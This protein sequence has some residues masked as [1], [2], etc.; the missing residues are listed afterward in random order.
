MPEGV[1]YPLQQYVQEYTSSST[2]P[3]VFPNPTAG[4]TPQHKPQWIQVIGAGTVV[5]VWEDGSTGTL[6]CLGGE[7][8]QATMNQITSM[9]ATRVRVG[10][11]AP[12]PAIA[13]GTA[14]GITL[15]TAVT[16]FTS[17][18]TVDAALAEIYQDLETAQGVVAFDLCNGFLVAGTP[19]AAFADNAASA[20]GV[21]VDNSKASA[22]RWNDAATQVAV[23]C[24]SV[25]IPSDM[26]VTKAST[27][28]VLCNKSGATSGDATTFDIAAYRQ[29]PAALEDADSN[30]GGTTGAV[31]GTATAK[32]VQ[33]VTLAI[34]ANTWAAFPS[35]L[36][37]S[38]KPT[39]G[40]LGT[41][42]MV[43]N[44]FYMTYQKKILAS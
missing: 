22:V 9:G 39:N 20:P 10:I 24:P 31:T 37:V 35:A 28:V 15:S 43:V 41:D 16:A 26:D 30:L 1:V 42:D 29:T 12:P 36:S 17:K 23:W 4:S 8:Y 40:T 6:V 38:I 27:F 13:N 21:T 7:V 5:V 33:K 25:V 2:Y 34:A 32:T 44:S 18:T 3:V 11:G 19:M 14:A